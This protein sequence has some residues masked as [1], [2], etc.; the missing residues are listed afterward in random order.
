M[1]RAISADSTSMGHSRIFLHRRGDNTSSSQC[2]RFSSSIQLR[3][4]SMTK[5]KSLVGSTKCFG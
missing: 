2:F 5:L 4:Q 1:E 3:A